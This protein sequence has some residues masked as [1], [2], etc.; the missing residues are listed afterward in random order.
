MGYFTDFPEIHSI[1][2]NA[3][4]SSYPQAYNIQSGMPKMKSIL[5]EEK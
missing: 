1:V 4:H 3:R 5:E 2:V